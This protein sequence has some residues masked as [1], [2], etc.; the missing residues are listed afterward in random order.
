[1]LAI[2]GKFL[3][4]SCNASIISTTAVFGQPPITTCWAT[5]CKRIFRAMG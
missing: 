5:H 4:K 2:I 3:G 1:M